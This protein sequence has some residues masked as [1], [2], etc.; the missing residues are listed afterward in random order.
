VVLFAAFA[1]VTTGILWFGDET[2]PAEGPPLVP[3]IRVVLASVATVL[4]ALAI[5]L[6]ADPTGL[7]GPSPFGLPPLGGR[8]AGCWI[9]LIAV[10][11]AWAAGRNRV[12]EAKL[13]ALALTAL[14]AGA[15]IAGLRTIDHLNPAGA[16]AGYLAALALLAACGAAVLASLRRVPTRE[17]A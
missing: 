7:A 6:W 8:F 1:L 17:R 15:L 5:A 16:A 11:C 3:G 2:E 12:D 14:P 4:G 9:A 13:P 10:L